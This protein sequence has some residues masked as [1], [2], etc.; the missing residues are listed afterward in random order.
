MGIIS[1]KPKKIANETTEIATIE[2]DGMSLKN[3]KE[4]D[5]PAIIGGQVEKLNELDKS[6]KKAISNAK[7]AA[8]SA[9]SARNKSVGLFQKKAAIEALQISG[10][11]MAQAIASEAEAQRISFD[12][13]AKLAE[14]S[15][16]LFALGVSNIAL[17]RSTVRLLQLKMKGAS[18]NKLSELAQREILSV[19]K[20]LKAQEDILI[21]QQNLEDGAKQNE[22]EL[23]KH[24]VLIESIDKKTRDT[25][26]KANSTFQK[27]KSL[28]STV[29]AHADLLS[30]LR[31]SVRQSNKKINE[32]DLK[33][34][35]YKKYF[36]I[37]C[38]ISGATLILSIISLILSIM[39]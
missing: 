38:I 9:D 2:D 32:F 18:K 28:L 34:S 1:K 33:F 16:F 21:R 31:R 17:N 12:F 39:K 24:D 19:I 5:L 14:I 3:I 10:Y 36:Y 23:K 35:Q 25:T 15:K 13:T 30:S 7:K 4:S 26:K 29:D 6:V 37:I 20:Q 22:R 27:I 11:D 8:D